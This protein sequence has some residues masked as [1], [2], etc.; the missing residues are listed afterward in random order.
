MFVDFVSFS[1]HS[2]KTKDKTSAVNTPQQI[3]LCFCANSM[4][5]QAKKYLDAGEAYLQHSSHR[6]AHDE[7][8]VARYYFFYF[9]LV[10]KP[11]KEKIKP[12]KN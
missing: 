1:D 4:Q 5:T 7:I 3:R 9:A 11:E 12:D 2:N 6:G 8:G 10:N